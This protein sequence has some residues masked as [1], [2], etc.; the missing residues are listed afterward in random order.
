M[1]TSY[2]L[3][4]KGVSIVSHQEQPALKICLQSRIRQTREICAYWLEL[5]LLED[6]QHKNLQSYTRLLKQAA[7]FDNV[8]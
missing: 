2:M 6:L 3:S 1:Y 4:S 7:A 5:K 8:L